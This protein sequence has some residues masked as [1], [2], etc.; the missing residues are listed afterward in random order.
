MARD[1]HCNDYYRKT[2]DGRLPVK[3]MAPEALFHRLYTTQS[4]VWSYGILLWEIM[5]LGGK[6]CTYYSILNRLMSFLN[7]YRYALSIRAQRGETIPTAQKW[8]QNGETSVLFAGNLHADERMLELSTQRATNV[9]RVGGRFGQDFNHNRER[10]V[11][12]FGA[13]AIGHAVVESGVQ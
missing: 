8:P 11:P 1:V 2:T 6:S 9:L 12:G 5:T 13:S 3:W 4:D 7:F 10:R